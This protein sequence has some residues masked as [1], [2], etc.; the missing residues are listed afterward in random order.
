VWFF[1]FILEFENGLSGQDFIEKEAHCSDQSGGEEEED[2]DRYDSSFINDGPES[3]TEEAS[4]TKKRP[5]YLHFEDS[6]DEE[7]VETNSAT[8]TTAAKKKASTDSFKG[9]RCSTPTSPDRETEQEKRMVKKSSTAPP[10]L[11]GN[12]KALEEYVAY[13]EKKVKKDAKKKPK[14][15]Q[16]SIPIPDPEDLKDDE[17]IDGGDLTK[18]EEQ[19]KKAGGKKGKKSFDDFSIPDNICNELVTNGTTFNAKYKAINS[20][21]LVSC[22]YITA[23][24]KDSF[25]YPALIFTARNK[26]KPDWHL[27]IN[28]KETVKIIRALEEFIEINPSFKWERGNQEYIAYSS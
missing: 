13:L 26:D 2:P 4:P 1:Y 23:N 16:P 25:S 12:R 17:S 28:F 21:R 14:N 10:P 19:E 27:K 15:S 22:A 5:R 9:K 20:T 6:E 7:T 18:E 11:K 3:E 24:T 8:K